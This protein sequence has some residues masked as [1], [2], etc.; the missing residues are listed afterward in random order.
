MPD[1]YFKICGKTVGQ[2]TL[3]V[4]TNNLVFEFVATK[5]PH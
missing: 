4:T 5:D 1:G 2:T 3:W